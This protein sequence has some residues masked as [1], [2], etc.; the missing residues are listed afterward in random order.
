MK[1]VLMLGTG[2]TIAS[3]VTPSGLGPGA[4]LGGAAALRAGDLISVQRD[5]RRAVFHRLDEC[6]SRALA[7]DRRCHPRPAMRN[8]TASSSPHG[9]DTMAYTAAALSYLIQYSPK[10]IILD[11]ARRSPLC[12]K[13]RIPR[14][15]WPMRSAALFRICAA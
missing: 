11:G 14:R 4:H 2:G 3:E 13:T 8:M 12:L 9:T 5:L 6:D 15:I 10:P 7:D 1:K